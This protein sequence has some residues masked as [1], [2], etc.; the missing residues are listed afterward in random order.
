MGDMYGQSSSLAR[1]GMFWNYVE[2]LGTRGCASCCNMRC[3]LWNNGTTMGLGIWSWN[4]CVFIIPSI[5][6]ACIRCLNHNPN[7]TIS[8]PIHRQTTHPPVKKPPQSASCHWICVFAQ[9]GYDN[10]LQT[11]RDEHVNELRWDG[12]CR[13]SL[14]VQ[15][16]AVAGWR[17][18]TW[19][20]VVRPLGCTAK[21]FETPLEK[22]PWWTFLQHANSTC[23]HNDT[24][25]C[26]CDKTALFRVAYYCWQPEAHLC[27]N[28]S[29]WAAS[30]WILS[31]RRSAH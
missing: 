5:R 4:L 13:N 6:R 30:W 2:V 15:T 27:N 18:G 26:A 1:T 7:A 9:V 10:K 21:F 22:A 14:V 8:H 17:G 3:R 19:S 29:V 24:C 20:T 11:G 28:H 12:A 16:E 23:R 25:G 31:K